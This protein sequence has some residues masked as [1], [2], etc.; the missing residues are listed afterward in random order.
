MDLQRH[1][2]SWLQSPPPCGGPGPAG[3][4]RARPPP[5][6]GPPVPPP[7]RPEPLG[8]SAGPGPPG[9]SRRPRRHTSPG[10][11]RR[12]LA[13]A[14]PASVPLPPSPSLP[15]PPPPSPP[16]L[17]HG[18]RSHRQEG[19]RDRERVTATDQCR[20]QAPVTTSPRRKLSEK[21]GGRSQVRKERNA[22]LFGRSGH[23][24]KASLSVLWKIWLVTRV[25]CPL[26]CQD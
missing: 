23:L 19:Q 7:R 10:P 22:I 15:L 25:F 21:R 20:R 24:F 18:E 16:R 17:G 2:G 3:R 11:A 8:A 5:A 6:R 1:Q 14:R 26:T 13:A 4:A 12:R 9:A